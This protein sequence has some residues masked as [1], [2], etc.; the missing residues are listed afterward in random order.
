V[1]SSKDLTFSRRVFLYLEFPL[2]GKDKER[3]LVLYKER[4]LYPKILDVYYVDE[5]NRAAS[6]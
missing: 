3:L 5:R 6:R 4:N 2:L 1:Q